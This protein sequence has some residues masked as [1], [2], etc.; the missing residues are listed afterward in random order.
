MVRLQCHVPD[1]IKSQPN[2]RPRMLETGSKNPLCAGI[3]ILAPGPL[4]Q[5]S[6]PRIQDL[7]FW[8]QDGYGPRTEGLNQGF[9][10]LIPGFRIQDPGSRRPQPGEYRE[11][12]K[13]LKIHENTQIH[14]NTRKSQKDTKTHTQHMWKYTGVHQ[15]TWK[16]IKMRDLHGFVCVLGVWTFILNV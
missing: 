14:K 1:Y 16:Y 2:S 8:I 7:G 11:Y 4:I 5:T 15:N 12:W 13:Y 6:E 3:R 9:R 10:I